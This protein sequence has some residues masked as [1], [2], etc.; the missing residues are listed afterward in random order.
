VIG[1]DSMNE[2]HEGF[3]GVEDLDEFPS[4]QSF[5]SAIPTLVLSSS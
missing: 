5:K 1:W 4:A 3:I 2:P